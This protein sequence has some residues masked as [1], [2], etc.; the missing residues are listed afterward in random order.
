MGKSV[1]TFVH[2]KGSLFIYF[3]IPPIPSPAS[4]FQYFTTTAWPSSFSQPKKLNSPCLHRHP[5]PPFPM[6]DATFWHGAAPQPPAATRPNYGLITPRPAP[7]QTLPS[8]NLICPPGPPL[9]LVAIPDSRTRRQRRSR[10]LQPR[11]SPSVPAPTCCVVLCCV[12]L[13]QE[14]QPQP[15]RCSCCPLSQLHS[16]PRPAIPMGGA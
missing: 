14:N 4:P 8:A 11:S 13:L 2:L 1:A 7:F 12:V 9:S 16:T 6:P 15:P 5:F 3:F 10:V